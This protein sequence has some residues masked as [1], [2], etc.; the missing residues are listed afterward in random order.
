MNLFDLIKS[1]KEEILKLADRHGAYNVRLFGSV[2]RKEENE[3]S[4]IDF[5]VDFKP[6]VGLFE[7]SSFWVELEDLLKHKVDVA[8]EKVLKESIKNRILKEAKPL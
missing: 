1:K 5:L 8:T 4:D 2:V 6:E 3:K 7:W